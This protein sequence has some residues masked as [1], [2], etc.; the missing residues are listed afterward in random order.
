MFKI[1]TTETYDPSLCVKEWIDQVKN[2]DFVLYITKHITSEVAKLFT[3]EDSSLYYGKIPSIIHA[4]CTGW[5]GDV[6]EY[7]VPNLEQTREDLFSLIS[8]GYPKER[9]V[10]R[11]DPIIPTQRGIDKFL[12]AVEIAYDLGITRVRSS[13]MQMYQHVSDRMEAESNHPEI[14]EIL[15]AYRNMYYNETDS[16]SKKYSFFP[17]KEYC[18]EHK[19]YEKLESVVNMFKKLSDDKMSFE[20][21]ASPVLQNAGFVNVG[22]MS[23]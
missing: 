6:L 13:M 11:V 1:A 16:S 22:C 20:S 9:I 2:Y 7:N 19:I 21:C 12:Y 15:N 10:L 4:T 23:N 14:I 3:E 18:N 8:R 5:G 17:T